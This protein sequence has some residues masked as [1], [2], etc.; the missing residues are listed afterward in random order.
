MKSS[1][2]PQ[3]Q[4]TSQE[5]EC[6]KAFEGQD[7]TDFGSGWARSSQGTL[8]N[9]GVISLLRSTGAIGGSEPPNPVG[10]LLLQATTPNRSDPREVEADAVASR[11][12]RGLT[13]GV[14]GQSN[15]DLC[16]QAV[17][18]SPSVQTVEHI[19]SPGDTMW[20]I[21]EQY[22]GDGNRYIEI[23]RENG[24]LNPD[25]IS[26]GQRLMIDTPAASPAAAPGGIGSPG[27]ASSVPG[28]AAASGALQGGPVATLNIH[29]DTETVNRSEL[30]MAELQNAQVG[31]SWVSLSYHD[32]SMVP[33]GLGNPTDG[34]LKS[35]GT[36]M[37]FWPLIMRAQGWTTPE[38]DNIDQGYTP[39][40][41]ASQDPTHTGFSLNPLKDVPGRV[42]EPDNAH[43]PKAT[44]AYEIQQT[45]VESMMT[46]VNGNRGHSYNLYGYNCTTFAVEAV[47][48]ANQNAPSGSN[49]GICLPNALYKDIY[50]MQ[51]NG[52]SSVTTAPL[53]P[54]ETNE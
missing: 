23:A 30:T 36:S 32:P 37:G 44:K 25:K 7:S 43:S 38:Q 53:Q 48:A 9:S 1:L 17:P 31:H 12:V 28:S 21:A 35:G 29:A 39:G 42:E 10:P 19:V 15:S 18:G 13:A 22:L 51:K 33:A 46:Y 11:V 34:L 50:E 3:Q 6:S 2:K 24:V 14:E 47:N 26:V 49:L 8:G 52:D 20:G 16:L 54:G 4:R 27:G 45:D 41:G 40:A 5:V